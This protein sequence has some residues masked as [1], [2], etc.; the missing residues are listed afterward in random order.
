M[1]IMTKI[2]TNAATYKETKNYKLVNILTVLSRTTAARQMS[3]PLK[4]YKS[5]TKAQTTLPFVTNLYV[6]NGIG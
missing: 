5:R 3:A 1:I 6:L 2:K 4:E